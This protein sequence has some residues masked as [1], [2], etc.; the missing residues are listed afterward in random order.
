MPVR[1]ISSRFYDSDVFKATNDALLEQF[2]EFRIER[3]G[4]LWQPQS[5]PE[6]LL[7]MLFEKFEVGPLYAGPG[8]IESDRM[9][10]VL[11]SAWYLVTH[12][13]LPTAL[14]TFSRDIEFVANWRLDKRSMPGDAT[15][16]AVIGISFFISPLVPRV[17]TDALRRYIVQAYRFL[18]RTGLTI[19]ITV[20][21]LSTVSPILVATARPRL[22]YR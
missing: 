7:P 9:R 14:T 22:I 15:D 3:A 8:I 11:S 1:D 4:T 12:L 2:Q 6:E 5:V 10:D 13:T 21:N 16:Q 18:T 20:Y 17:I 19:N